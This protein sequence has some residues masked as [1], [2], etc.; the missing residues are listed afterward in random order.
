M[1]SARGFDGAERLMG[2]AGLRGGFHYRDAERIYHFYYCVPENIKDK[3]TG[4]PDE[5]FKYGA[6]KPALLTYDED[7]HIQ[8][9]IPGIR[10]NANTIF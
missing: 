8:K 6:Y 9:R 2:F 10:Q 1:E 4:F 7:G 3:V 5:N